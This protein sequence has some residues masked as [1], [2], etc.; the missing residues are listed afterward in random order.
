MSAQILIGD[1]RAHLR[2]LKRDSVQTCVTSPPYWGL[3]EYKGGEGMIGLE[4][5][6]QEH[7]DNLLE[8][9]G[10]VAWAM[11]DDGTLWLNYGDVYVHTPAAGIKRRG[12]KEKASARDHRGETCHPGLDGLP[13]KNLMGLPWRV[14]FALQ[15]YGWILRSA[16]VLD[17]QCVLPEAV[18]DRPTTSYEFLF[19]FSQQG[20][21][22]Y[23]H[24]AVRVPSKRYKPVNTPAYY[25]WRRNAVKDKTPRGGEKER[26]FKYPGRANL[27][28]VWRIGR[29]IAPKGH[30]ATFSPELV[31]PCVLAG[32]RPGDT[33]LDPFAGSGTTGMVALKH[34]R[35]AV[36]IDISPE[37]ADI[38][39]RRTAQEALL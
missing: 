38:M 26:S 18:T 28:N 14:A 32:S 31:E 27:R 33:V 4:A 5:S 6:W 30:F 15:E 12:A 25:E 16:I 19:L 37:Y 7:L 22:Y 1:C 36:L 20:Q 17:K 39:T 13:P 35:K 34:R 3:R 10:A 9:F 21:Y 8:V 2:K 29:H 23:D 24:E 11:R